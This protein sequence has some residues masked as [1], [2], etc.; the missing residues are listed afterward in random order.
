MTK[1]Y[2]YPAYCATQSNRTHRSSGYGHGS[3]AAL[4]EVP[5]RHTNVAAVPA[6]A[7]FEKGIPVPRGMCHGRTQLT[8]FPHAGINVPRTELTEVPVRVPGKFTPGMVLYVREPSTS[9]RIQTQL[10]PGTLKR[11]I[12]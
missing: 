12:E 6:P 2:P 11:R 8:A 5:G 1:V 3:L 4:T 10:I 7:Y 9:I